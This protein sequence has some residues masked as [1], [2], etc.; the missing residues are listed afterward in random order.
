[1]LDKLE[2][3][4]FDLPEDLIAKVPVTPRDHSRLMVIDRS[5]GKIE[6]IPFYELP[7]FLGDGD[8]IVFNNTKVIPAR[9]IGRKETG[10][11]VELLLLEEKT[12]G[13]WLTMAR[14]ARKLK[15]GTKVIVSDRLCAEM[16]E[17]LDEGMRLV[18][19]DYEGLFWEVLAAHGE[20]PLPPYLQ[21]DELPK[22][23]RER[24]QTIYAKHAGAVAAPTAGLHFTKTLLEELTE[25]GVDIVEITLHVGLGTFRPVTAKTITEHK[26]HEE[27]YWI[28]QEAASR[29]NRPAKREICVGTTCCRAL[30]SA[31]NEQGN[32]FS[33]EGR[34]DIF[35]RPG[36]QFKKVTSLLTNFHLPGS[37]LMMLVSAFAG[38]DLTMNAYKKAVLDKFRFFSYGDAMLIL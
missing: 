9:L 27:R 22:L 14:P 30:E 6:E 11:Q 24:Y 33:G 21:R 23:D 36:Y 28:T 35:I 31:V 25:K 37:T 1:M 3:Y 12:E 34:T 17:E 16:I 7:Q 15:K 26:M 4:Q 18:R 5:S 29:L 8:R 38:Y 20:M 2:S 10:G 19:F 32:V 13:V